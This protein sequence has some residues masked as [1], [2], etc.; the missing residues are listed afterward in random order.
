MC[1]QGEQGV[2]IIKCCTYKTRTIS[3]VLRAVQQKRVLY[4]EISSTDIYNHNSNNNS[5]NINGFSRNNNQQ[6]TV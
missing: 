1:G 3:F 6:I 2:L 5:N 4:E